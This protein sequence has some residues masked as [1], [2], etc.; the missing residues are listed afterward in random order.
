MKHGD[1]MA[2]GIFGDFGLGIKIVKT[3]G[4][5]TAIRISP[6]T[7]QYY[8]L[9]GIKLDTMIN[10]LYTSKKFVWQSLK[11]GKVMMRGF[12][13]TQFSYSFPPVGLKGGLR[14]FHSRDALH[15]NIAT[16]RVTW[17]SFL[18][19]VSELPNRI[20]GS[21]SL[22]NIPHLYPFVKLWIVASWPMADACKLG[23][24]AWGVS[25]PRRVNLNAALE[26]EIV[27]V[28]QEFPTKQHLV[29]GFD[30][31]EYTWW[32]SWWS[33]IMLNSYIYVYLCIYIFVDV[34]LTFWFWWPLIFKICMLVLDDHY[35]DTKI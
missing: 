13:G 33:S 24:T 19:M 6:W 28:W 18:L 10:E 34:D 30:S 5:K 31:H 16:G 15:V 20:V 4:C 2:N 21:T 29:D 32:T 8:A 27:R 25:H 26:G 22:F 23:V 35:D 11:M 14:T 3:D 7:R 9:M 1:R 17:V 12:G